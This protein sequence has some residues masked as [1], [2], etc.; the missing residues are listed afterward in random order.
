MRARERITIHHAKWVGF[1]P[2]HRKSL[3]SNPNWWARV[4]K[5]V[6]H[7][8]SPQAAMEQVE[9]TTKGWNKNG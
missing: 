7:G 4:A 3:V 6:R 9:Q 1:A 2:A 5:L 8:L